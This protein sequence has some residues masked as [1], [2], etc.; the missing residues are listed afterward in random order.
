[1]SIEVTISCDALECFAE[2]RV[3]DVD[4][5]E[6]QIS[7]SKWE[8]DPDVYGQ[9]YCPKCWKKILQERAEEEEESD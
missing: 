4:E 5:V 8:H 6:H 9:H 2:L 1:M 3:D 7:W